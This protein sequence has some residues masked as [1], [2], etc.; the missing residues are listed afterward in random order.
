MELDEIL[1]NLELINSHLRDILDEATDRWGVKVEAVEIREVDPVGPV[2]AAMEEQTASER[3]R[4]AAIL[5]ADGSKRASILK[6]EGS[7]RARILQ[8]EG[9]RQSAIL[10]AEGERLA[11]ILTA[12]GEAQKLRILSLGAAPLDQKALTVLSL[13]TLK[14]VGNGIST[15]IIFPFEISKLLEGAS[16]YIGFS[17]KVPERPLPTLEDIEKQV[18]KADEVLGKIPKPEDLKHELETIEQ[19][20]ESEAAATEKLAMGIRAKT[21]ISRTT[22]TPKVKRR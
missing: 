18:G 16:E 4:R 2:K 15:K 13:D 11:R 3:E 9:L 6:A 12:Q 19:Q 1:Y 20:M 14:S 5:R 10:E 17:R 21:D 8:A 22:K 7:K